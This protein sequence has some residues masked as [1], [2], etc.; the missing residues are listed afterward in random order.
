[1]RVE[2]R[3]LLTGGGSAG[4]VTVHLALIPKLR[5]AGW[6]VDY[7]GSEQGIE[8]QLVSG[9][10]GVS[11][12]AVATGKFRRYFDWKN[13]MDPLKVMRGVLQAYRIIRERRPQVIFS[14]GGFVS[15]PVVIGG[16]MN[17]VPVVIHESDLTPGL[18]NRIAIPFATSVCMTFAETEKHLPAGKAVHIGAIVRPELVAGNTARGLLLCDFVRSKP[19]LLLMGG[20]LGSQRLNQALRSV[21]PQLLTQFQVVHI[22]GQGNVDETLRQRG[23]RQFEYVKEEL[24]DLLAMADLVLSRAGANA[25]FE[26]LALY[27]PMLLVP[28]SLKASRG[29]QIVNARSFERLGY[30]MVLP[31][32]QASGEALLDAIGDLYRRREE[33][34]LRM[35]EYE[36]G[37]P[38][39]RLMQTIEKTASFS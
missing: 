30:A 12:F 15:V 11:Y 6:K 19:V 20:S 21:L 25:I 35:K 4:H 16:W 28:L 10:D 24:P 1:M 31:E 32:E 18:A 26:F 33:V 38:L 17:R 9:I 37:D 39:A 13:A 5:A 8:R 27:K 36:A 34:V 2:R 14:K 23:Y 7:I 22:C 29:D 3:I